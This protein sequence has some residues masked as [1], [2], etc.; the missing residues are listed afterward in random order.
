MNDA[1]DQLRHELGAEPSKGLRELDP[2]EQE[3]L[4][5]LLAIARRRQRRELEAAID[6]GLAFVPRLARGAVKKA[7]FG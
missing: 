7:L 1:V 5:E 3:R 4:A 6:Q 2:T